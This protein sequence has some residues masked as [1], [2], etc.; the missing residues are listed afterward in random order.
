MKILF[1]CT[2]VP[3][4]VEGGDVVIV[5]DGYFFC[6]YYMIQSECKLIEKVKTIKFM[7]G[8]VKYGIVF[9]YSNLVPRKGI[10]ELLQ[11]FICIFKRETT[12]GFLQNASDILLYKDDKWD[13]SLLQS[14][15]F[16][17][18]YTEEKSNRTTFADFLDEQAKYY[19]YKQIDNGFHISDAY[20][21]T[22]TTYPK[23]FAQAL[24][25]FK[26]AF[27]EK[28]IYDNTIDR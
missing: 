25:Q 10:Q 7:Q 4:E 17:E 15:L 3:T 27:P 28:S 20:R 24:K 11:F 8:S 5:K 14:L 22:K 26:T 13:V 2:G 1:S 19:F 6:F 21:L 12:V 23:I 9:E 16:A 18:Q